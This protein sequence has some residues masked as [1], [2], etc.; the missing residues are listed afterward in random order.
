MVTVN[1]SLKQVNCHRIAKPP[2]VRKP[3]A[4]HRCHGMGSGRT[5]LHCLVMVA[6]QRWPRAGIYPQSTP[7]IPRSSPVIPAVP[8]SSPQFPRHPRSSPVIPAV[9]PSS[10]RKRG[11]YIN[12]SQS[13]HP[14]TSTAARPRCCRS[15]KM[16]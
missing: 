3:S 4:S 15:R 11:S 9:P 8:P 2:P 13:S 12:G 1:L 5:L 10:P 16:I 14:V 6:A 7:L